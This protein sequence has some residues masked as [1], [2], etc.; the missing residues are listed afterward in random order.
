MVR[1]GGELLRSFAASAAYLKRHSRGLAVGG[2]IWPA[3]IGPDLSRGFRALKIWY[4]LKCLGTDRLGAAM[5][6]CCSLAWRMTARIRSE[7][8]LELLLPTALNIV[9]FRYR[10]DR[11]GE[12]RTLD[13]AADIQESGRAVLSTTLIGDRPVLRCAIVNHRTREEDVDA[14]IDCVLELGRLRNA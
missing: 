14:V 6:R 5:E 1:E 11:E 13:L 8:E 10:F 3:D 9:V 4:T 2:E 12:G 7:P